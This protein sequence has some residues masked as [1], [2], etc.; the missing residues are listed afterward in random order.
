MS[1]RLRTAALVVLPLALVS[2]AVAAWAGPYWLERGREYL[3]RQR[4][5]QQRAHVLDAVAGLALPAGYVEEPC[6][7]APGPDDRCW[8]VDARPQD[9]TADLVAALTAAGVEGV[10]AETAPVEGTSVI[11]LARGSLEGREVGLFATEEV[12]EE[13]TLAAG[14]LVMRPGALVRSTADVEEP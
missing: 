5:P 12:D 1:R 6:G 4:W 3:D 2:V 9:V 11:A 14:T 10:L 13:A 7:G 8:H